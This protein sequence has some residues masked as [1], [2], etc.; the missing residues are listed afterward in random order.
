VEA[1]EQINL[2]SLLLPILAVIFIIAVSVIVLN[3]HFQKNLFKQKLVQEELVIKHQQDLLK[4]SIDVQEDERKRMA[5]DLHDEM[6]ATLS[7]IRMKISSLEKE[8]SQDANLQQQFEHLKSLT[9][10][11]MSSIRRI[12]H[13]LMPP[14]LL[15]FGLIS[16]LNQIANTV[17]QSNPINVKIN[18]PDEQLELPWAISLGLYRISMEL[19]N[20]TIKHAKANAVSINIKIENQ[21]LYFKYEDN[22]I[23]ISNINEHKGLGQKSIEARALAMNGSLKMGNGEQKGFYAE[24][25][26]P[27]NNSLN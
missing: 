21:I 1:S 20:N 16:S 2:F 26:I 4:S 22:G 17:Q 5:I 18:H 7:L 23:G 19:I 12:S 8:S 14:T 3:S 9:D 13:D 11:A 10:T 24:I 25:K 15:Y 6:G 27:I